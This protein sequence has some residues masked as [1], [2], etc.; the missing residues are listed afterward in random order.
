MAGRLV[1]QLVDAGLVTEAQARSSDS[2]DRLLP[3]GQVVQNLVAAGLDERALAGFF[4]S[5]GFGPMLQS[6]ELARA[7]AEPRSPFAG[8]RRARSLCDAAAAEP[9]GCDRRDGRSNRRRCRDQ[10]QRGAWWK[11]LADRGEALRS[12]GVDRP[13]LSTGTPPRRHG[14]GGG[15]S[16]SNAERCRA[17]RS[18]KGEVGTDETLSAFD[19]S[20]SELASTASP[21]WDRAWN[22]STTEREV[23]LTPKSSHIPLP[24]VSRPPD[25]T[26]ALIGSPCHA[27]SRPKRVRLGHRCSSRRAR[28]R[29]FA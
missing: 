17:A 9:R 29:H 6:A 27:C 1:E 13:G 26:V 22:R 28:T 24:I 7:D 18:G 2:G 20:L 21:V 3:S 8:G 5:L 10:A 4:V 12:A 19:P 15:A 25:S 23:S 11:H 16:F 14:S